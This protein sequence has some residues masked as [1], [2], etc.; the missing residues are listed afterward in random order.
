MEYLAGSL[1][2][3]L[4]IFIARQFYEVSKPNRIRINLGFRQSHIFEVV[5]PTMQE[6]LHSKVLKTQST[7]HFDKSKIKVVIT[8]LPIGLRTILCTRL[9]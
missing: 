9:T 1:V 5:R 8:A 3:I 2:T 7:E 4:L 6:I